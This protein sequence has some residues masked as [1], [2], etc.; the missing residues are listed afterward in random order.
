MA[1]GENN[2]VFF[3]SALRILEALRARP[4]ADIDLCP[5]E[6]TGRGAAPLISDHRHSEKPRRTRRSPSTHHLHVSGRV[7]WATR[8]RAVSEDTLTV[9]N[10]GFTVN[11]FS[12][13]LLPVRPQRYTQTF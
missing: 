5:H 3:S 6:M 11:Y 2:V 9:K 7:S 8:R 13:I 10:E 1:D 12:I 4:P